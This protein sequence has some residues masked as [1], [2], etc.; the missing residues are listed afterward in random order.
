MNVTHHT[1]RNIFH[2]KII[3]YPL[4]F[5]MVSIIGELVQVDIISCSVGAAVLF[6]LQPFGVNGQGGLPNDHNVK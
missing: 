1:T 5:F 4:V 6:S 2:S 3:Y